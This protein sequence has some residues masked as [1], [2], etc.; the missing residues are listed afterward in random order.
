MEKLERRCQ[1]GHKEFSK[2]KQ[3][4]INIQQSDNLNQ[5]NQ[6][7]DCDEESNEVKQNSRFTY[8]K[9]VAMYEDAIGRVKNDQ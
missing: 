7:D 9:W 8:K 2:Y 5:D 3:N 6:E 4:W 1:I